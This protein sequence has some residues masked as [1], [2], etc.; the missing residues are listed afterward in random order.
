MDGEIADD[1]N[2]FAQTKGFN[3]APSKWM[4]KSASIFESPGRVNASME[5]HLNG[6]GKRP[7]AMGR[8]ADADMLQ[9]SPI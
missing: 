5:P 8:S 6:W 1:A 9:W 4:G 2:L 3:G 7:G